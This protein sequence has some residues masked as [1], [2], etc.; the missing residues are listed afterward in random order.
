MKSELY[1]LIHK[2]WE[3]PQITISRTNSKIVGLILLEKFF[4]IRTHVKME[5]K[6]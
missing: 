4:S 2:M 6:F 3:L 5:F 1:R